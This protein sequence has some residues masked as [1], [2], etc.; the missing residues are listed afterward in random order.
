MR[1]EIGSTGVVI[2]MT[3]LLTL[4]IGQAIAYYPGWEAVWLFIKDNKDA[5]AWIQAVGSIGAIIGSFFL[6]NLSHRL[7]ENSKNK[8]IEKQERVALISHYGS[9]LNYKILLSGLV[10]TYKG[11]NQM[12]DIRGYCLH[13]GEVLSSNKLPS[14]AEIKS[15]ANLT[16]LGASH[17]A[18]AD[19]IMSG[20]KVVLAQSQGI[21]EGSDYE[22]LMEMK[23]DFNNRFNSAIR[24]LDC[25]LEVLQPFLDHYKQQLKIIK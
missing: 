23:I 7:A 4:L 18:H 15:I 19:N 16:E 9:I 12:A 1:E 10:E 13:I 21:I 25:A 6:A 14:L 20:A 2:G 3:I 11:A 24:Y 17:L 8:E 5:P 22:L